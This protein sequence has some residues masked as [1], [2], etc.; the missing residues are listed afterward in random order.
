MKKYLIVI[1]LLSISFNACNKKEE[2]TRLSFSLKNMAT[3]LGET[4]DYISKV[5]PGKNT[6]EEDGYM[7]YFLENEIDGIDQVY[8]CYALNSINECSF[9]NLLSNSVNSFEDADTLIDLA[10]SEFGTAEYYYLS[11]YDDSSALHEQTYYSTGELRTCIDTAGVNVNNIDQVFGL[12]HYEK[13]YIL[14]GG[15]YSYDYGGFFS[16]IEI[17]Y[18]DKLPTADNAM[19]IK[20]IITPVA[21]LYPQKIFRSR[22]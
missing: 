12:Y 5:S 3:L 14:A 4:S 11:Y 15:Y 17:G 8:I 13:Y 20:K 21:Y 6:Q 19:I 7:Y 22:K 9:I 1:I 10:E 16:L 18:Y 2:Y